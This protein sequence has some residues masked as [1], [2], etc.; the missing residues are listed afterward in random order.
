MRKNISE[1]ADANVKTYRDRCN[2]Q[3]KE[4]ANGVS[5]HNDV[6][7]ECCP[8][9]SCC[10]PELLAHEEIRKTFLNASREQRESMCYAFLG[11]SLSLV[12]PN[13]NI[14]IANGKDEI[15]S[16]LN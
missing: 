15:T 5:Y 9:F 1:I 14:H 8:D 7:D 4:W 3:V 11:S 12:L 6:E 2:L 13:K 16:P 10:K